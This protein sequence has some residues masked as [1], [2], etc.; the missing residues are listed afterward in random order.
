MLRAIDLM[1]GFARSVS[2]GPAGECAIAK[3]PTD[4]KRAP[5]APPPLSIAAYV[6]TIWPLT[7]AQLS[8]AFI[9]PF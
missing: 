4:P 7:S 6:M 3:S 1:T 8:L 5:D 9:A 2:R